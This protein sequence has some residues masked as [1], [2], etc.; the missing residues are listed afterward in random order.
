[1]PRVE[2]TEEFRRRILEKNRAISIIDGNTQMATTK[3]ADL[4]QQL[5][6]AIQHIYY[7]LRNRNFKFSNN[8]RGLVGNLEKQRA[9]QKLF[10]S[11]LNSINYEDLATFFPECKYH[12]YFNL[13]AKFK[14]I[15]EINTG[16]GITFFSVANKYARE[17]KAL[18]SI[19]DISKQ[20]KFRIT[21]DTF[22]RG[23]DQNATKLRHF[24][25]ECSK[26]EETLNFVRLDLYSQ[27]GQLYPPF[28]GQTDLREVKGNFKKLLDYIKIKLL[29]DTFVGHAWKLSSS[30]STHYHYQLLIFCLPV[31]RKVDLSI[32][33]TIGKHWVEITNGVGVFYRHEGISFT[34]KPY[35]AGSINWRENVDARARLRMLSKEVFVND[36]YVK[37]NLGRS[38]KSFGLS[39]VMDPRESAKDRKKRKQKIKLRN[40]LKNNQEYLG[41]MTLPFRLRKPATAKKS[42]INKQSNT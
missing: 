29:K 9:F 28:Q 18:E 16:R 27:S 13:F 41:D 12:P 6:F 5:F 11:T 24:F 14:D 35:E 19:R 26:I 37:P 34:S 36:Y 22:R 32:G 10:F 30:A 15:I 20:D 4:L 21:L 7:L 39:E 42:R 25:S 2:F 3:Q 38:F 31:N 40:K 1:M 8:P 33:D 17:N 23:P